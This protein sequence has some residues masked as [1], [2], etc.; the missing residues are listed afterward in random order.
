MILGGF[1]G[2]ATTA[3]AGSGEQRPV[4]SG[5]ADD[6]AFVLGNAETV[7]IV[8]V[9]RPGPWRAPSMP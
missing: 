1:G 6:A 8:P 4:K 3:V 5:S 9:L 7:V 2:D